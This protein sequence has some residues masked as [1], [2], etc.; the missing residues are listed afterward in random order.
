ME[1]VI[2]YIDYSVK[3]KKLLVKLKEY[4]CRFYRAYYGIIVIEDIGK[5]LPG[6]V[7]GTYAS[8]TLTISYHDEKLVLSTKTTRLETGLT[9]IGLNPTVNKMGEPVVEVIKPYTI[10]A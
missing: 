8:E 6:T 2:V 1:G 9:L 7:I 3:E 4:Q 10:T 5:A